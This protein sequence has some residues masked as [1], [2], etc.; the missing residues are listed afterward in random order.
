MAIAPPL[1]RPHSHGKR[2]PLGSSLGLPAPAYAAYATLKA[3]GECHGHGG[4]DGSQGDEPDGP[5]RQVES[6]GGL[7]RGVGRMNYLVPQCAR[8]C[9]SWQRLCSSCHT[10]L[11]SQSEPRIPRGS[12]VLHSQSP[13]SHIG[14]TALLSQSAPRSDMG[15]LHSANQHSGCHTDLQHCPPNH[16]LGSHMGTSQPISTQDSMWTCSIAHPIRVQAPPQ[17]HCIA[18]PIGT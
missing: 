6:D 1:G 3:G 9:C 16:S 4:W 11:P 15:L 17:T 8:G 7:Q 10:A 14:P 18:Q 2:L 12:T 13:G 5:C